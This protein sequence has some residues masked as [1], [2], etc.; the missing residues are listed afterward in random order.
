MDPE[1][2]DRKL[3]R[4]SK[5]IISFIC[6]HPILTV[7]QSLKTRHSIQY[8]GSLLLPE[9]LYDNPIFAITYAMAELYM[10]YLV[11]MS[12]AF[13]ALPLYSYMLMVK[14]KLYILQNVTKKENLLVVVR[15]FKETFVLNIYSNNYFS[16]AILP[17]ICFFNGMYSAF[18]LALIIK[19]NIELPINVFYNISIG[20]VVLVLLVEVFCVDGAKI[21]MSSNKVL[22]LLRRSSQANDYKNIRV[23]RSCFNLKVKVGIFFNFIPLSF[24]EFL[25]I[26]FAQTINILLLFPNF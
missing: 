6:I 8:W 18:L 5:F 12:L 23:L 3:A 11:L 10:F 22:G 14:H 19:K 4:N 24:L 26:L 13:A 16:S 17:T 21:W 2:S 7:L 9:R 1:N 15:L 20:V 25:N